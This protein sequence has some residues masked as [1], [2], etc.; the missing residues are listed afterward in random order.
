MKRLNMAR[1]KHQSDTG[2]SLVELMVGMAMV[3]SIS[4]SVIAGF[5]STSRASHDNRIISRVN[6]EARTTLDYLTYD[7]RMIGSGMPLGQSAFA[8]G[9]AGLGDAPLPILLDA[10]GTHVRVRINEKGNDMVLSADFTPSAGNTTFS[11]LTVFDLEAGDTVYFSDHSIGGTGGLK[12]VVAAIN[13]TNVTLGVGYTATPG[14]T[15]KSGTIVSRVTE[16]IY[17]S[18]GVATGIQRNA[19]L[20]AVTLQ[21]RSTFS[22]EYLDTAGAVVPLPLTDA[23]VAT[24]LSRIRVTVTVQSDNQLSTGGTYTAT[25]TQTVALRNLL[26]GRG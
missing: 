21:P 7:L 2:S 16:V 23:A 24:N 15:F 1:G 17:D 6:E 13:G 10:T 11:V 4:A 3:A 25:A 5:I 20:G 8:I 14:L 26:L 9:G 22:L 12:G 19:E 18:V